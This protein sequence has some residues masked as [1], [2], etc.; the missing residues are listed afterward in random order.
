MGLY[1]GK[2]YLGPINHF[3]LGQAVGLLWQVYLALTTPPLRRP[4]CK[5]VGKYWQDVLLLDT[6]CVSGHDVLLGAK[7]RLNLICGEIHKSKELFSSWDLSQLYAVP[8]P[9]TC[10]V[11]RRVVVVVSV[12][13]SCLSWCRC[14]SVDVLLSAVTVVA[15]S[16]SCTYS[17]L[18]WGKNRQTTQA[19]RG[20]PWTGAASRGSLLSRGP[21]TV[22][23]ATAC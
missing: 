2:K 6:M 11:A 10:G 5:L 4:S 12:L 22:P 23:R 14:C 3:F 19:L 17:L 16:R 8:R 13:L 9:E 18:L 20:L 7:H 21:L 1:R 15:D